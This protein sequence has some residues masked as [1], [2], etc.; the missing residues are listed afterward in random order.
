MLRDHRG[1]FGWGWQ[2]GPNGPEEVSRDLG[3]SP[4]PP[5]RPAPHHNAI[6]A[7]QGHC[8]PRRRGINDIAIGDDGDR[9]GVLDRRNCRP[10]GRAFVELAPRAPVDR[11]H[12]DARA[13]GPMRQFGGIEKCV[14]PTEPRLERHR[15]LDRRHHR[16]DQGQRMVEIFQERRARIAV[17]DLLGG[18][19]HVDVDKCRAA[20]LDHPRRL[21]HPIGLAAG[22]LNRGIGLIEPEL[23]LLAHTGFGLHHLLA[24]DHF[25]DDPARAPARDKLAE[26]QVGDSGKRRKRDGRGELHAP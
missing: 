12:P 7:R 10:I 24:C 3:Q 8:L 26:W 4:R 21:G 18:A 23:G 15:H 16:F 11:D 25:R 1:E 6:G 19:A 9:Y 5:L 13:F 14:V 17:G 22:D 20:G 2:D